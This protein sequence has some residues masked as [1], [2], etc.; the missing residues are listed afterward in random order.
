M[1][2]H[3][4]ERL[5]LQGAA[6]GAYGGGTEGT[7]WLIAFWPPLPLAPKARPSSGRAGRSSPTSLNAR[8]GRRT[9]LC[10]PSDHVTAYYHHFATPHLDKPTHF[11][12][13]N[14]RCAGREVGCPRALVFTLASVYREL[15]FGPP[16]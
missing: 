10:V 12:T 2:A 5:G 6:A 3:E 8:L 7:L 1:R 14:K 11:I 4:A 15:S 9:Q 16:F 13:G